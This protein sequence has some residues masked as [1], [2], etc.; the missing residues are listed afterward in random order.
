[1]YR[2]DAEQFA[3]WMIE[4]D[5]TPETL[6]RSDMIAYRAHLQENYKKAT[7][8]RKLVI[9][10]KLAKNPAYGMK[11]FKLDDETTHVVLNRV[12][13]PGLARHQPL[14]GLRDYVVILPCCCAPACDSV[15]PP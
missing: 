7:A 12:R 5:L 4:H 11:G 9:G 2:I 15:K 10:E 13:G 3:A 14:L 8:A 6:T 1:M